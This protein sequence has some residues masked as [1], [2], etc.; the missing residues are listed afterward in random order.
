MNERVYASGNMVRHVGKYNDKRCVVVLQLP[1]DKDNVFIIDTDSLPDQYHDH[2]MR[3]VESDEAQ[4][5]VWLGEILNRRV[6]NGGENALTAYF[7]GGFITSVPVSKVYMMPRPNQSIPLM[8]VID[9]MRTAMP[10][11]PAAPD[12]NSQQSSQAQQPNPLNESSNPASQENQGEIAGSSDDFN[13]PPTDNKAVA[14][15]LLIEADMLEKDAAQKRQQA[16]EMSPELKNSGTGAPNN[17]VEE[18]S[19]SA[20]TIA[21]ATSEDPPSSFGE[22][23]SDSI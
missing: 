14:E 18:D 19:E 23:N 3:I 5:S 10:N 2:L 11:D 21:T 13:L 1:E 12:P 22:T 16:Y 20:V 8:D 15:G 4:Q 7:K 9:D 6:M 17:S